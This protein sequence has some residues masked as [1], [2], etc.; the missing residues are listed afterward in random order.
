MPRGLKTSMTMCIASG[1]WLMKA[2]TRLGTWRSNE[3]R[4]GLLGVDEVRELDRVPDEEDAEVV[5][6]EIPVAVLGVELH[7]EAARVAQ[8]LGGVAAAGDGREA[9]GDVAG[10]A[11]LEDLRPG[12]LGDV[13]ITPRAVGLEGAEGGEAASVD[14]ALGDALA[15]EVGHLLEELV[16][17]ERRGTALT[18][19][20]LVLVVGDGMALAGRELPAVVTLGGRLGRDVG[21]A[22]S[23]SVVG[24]A[25]QSGQVPQ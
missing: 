13:L 10:L 8:A 21:H 24:L 2:K 3:T 9:Q 20:P 23:L 12:V 15:V 25:W 19:R 5:P 14:H 1:V 6:D 18:H 7:R 4:V 11:G 22:M 17:L 16:V